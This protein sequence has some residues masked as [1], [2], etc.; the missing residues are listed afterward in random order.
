MKLFTGYQKI[1]SKLNSSVITIGNFDGVHIG[2]RRILQYLLEQ[3][4]KENQLACVYTF[5]PHPRFALRKISEIELIT[6]YDERARLISKLGVDCLIEE[7][8]NFEFSQ[9]DSKTFFSD[10]LLGKLSATSVVVGHD[11]AFGK[12]R[13]GNLGSLARFCKES[14]IRLKIFEAQKNENGE[15]ISSSVIRQMI[16]QGKVKDANQFLGRPFHYEGPVVHGHRRG[17]QIGIPTANIDLPKEKIRIGTGVYATE[18]T[19]PYGIFR[20]ATNAGFRPT[21]DANEKRF[22]VETHILNFDKVLY[23][24]IIEVRFIE[25]I[26]DEKKFSSVD[27]LVAQVKRDIEKVSEI[28]K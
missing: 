9:I 12:N 1:T 4:K 26:R 11:F 16:R 13:D 3:A 8:F 7:P 21:F 14:N 19:T 20:G 28:L 2:H 25:K 6:S 10:I 15:I 18:I 24:K 17:G 5:K 27:D 22:S 23:G